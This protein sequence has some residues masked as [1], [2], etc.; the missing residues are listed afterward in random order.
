MFKM[1]W[2]WRGRIGFSGFCF[3]CR[4]GSG[5]CWL[6]FMLGVV[7]IKLGYKYLLLSA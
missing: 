3:V 5:Y 7:D 2:I 4:L 6:E 1:N